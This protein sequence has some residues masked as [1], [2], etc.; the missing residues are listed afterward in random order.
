MNAPLPCPDTVLHGDCVRLMGRM[1]EAC[2]DLVLTDPPYLCRYRSRDGRSVRNDD[3]ARWLRPAFAEMHRV[4]KPGGLCVSFYGWHQVDT[5]MTAWRAAGFRPVGHLVFPKRYAS[6][7]RFLRTMHEQ[8]YVLAKAGAPLPRVDL[9]D[10]LPWAYTGNRLH[11]TQKPVA[12]LRPVIERLCPPGG[13]VLDPFCGSGSTLLAAR[14]AGRRAIGMDLDAGH[15]FTAGMRL[16][17]V[18]TGG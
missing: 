18:E 7:S 4:L 12:A 11:P 2:V 17:G 5:F 9:P 3:N 8:A 16:H 1:L 13:L 10:V 14:M 15:V 6:S